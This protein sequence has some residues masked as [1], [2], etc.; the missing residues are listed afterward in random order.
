MNS[1]HSYVQKWGVFECVGLFFMASSQFV[2]LQL[3]FLRLESK[4]LIR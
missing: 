2:S 1:S 4:V 3:E